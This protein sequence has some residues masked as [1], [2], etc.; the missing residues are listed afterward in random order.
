MQQNDQ[1]I[2]CSLH[3]VNGHLQFKIV[4]GERR[5]LS[6]CEFDILV[7][8]SYIRIF[9][10]NTFRLG[11]GILMKVQKQKLC[12]LCARAFCQY[13]GA[14]SCELTLGTFKIQNAF[15][16]VDIIN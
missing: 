9:V 16:I 11:V 15:A 5:A 12:T 3:L 4:N 14:V 6:V 10:L 2:Q 8:F 13:V 1:N 7:R